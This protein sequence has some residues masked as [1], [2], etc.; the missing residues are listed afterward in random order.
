MQPDYLQALD[1]N[2]VGEYEGFKTLET[3]SRPLIVIATADDFRLFR[4]AGLGASAAMPAA[5]RRRA[6]GVATAARQPPGSRAAAGQPPGSA[7]RQPG[8]PAGRRLQQCADPPRR[9]RLFARACA[10]APPISLTAGTA[11]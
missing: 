11:T 2:F 1:S 4:L 9:C 7:R 8:G 5:A 3:S 10:L 6:G